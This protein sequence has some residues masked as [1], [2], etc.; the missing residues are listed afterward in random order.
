[1]EIRHSV[2]PLDCPDACAVLINVENGVGSRLRGDPQHPITQGF[3][4]A[5]VTKYLDRQYSSQR[6]LYPLKRV[7]AKGEGRFER[8]S[9]DEAL[10]TIATRLSSI[11]DEF[12]PEA[13]LPYSYAGTMGLLNGSGMDRRFFH[14]LGASRLDR[15]ICS[16]AG[17][18]GMTRAQGVRYSTE[19]EQF[20]ES[21]LILAWGANIHATNVHLW[22]F[23][24][25]ARRRG[26]KLYTIDPVLTRTG[27]LADKH[28]FINPGSDLAL[29]LGLMHVIIGERLYDADY[30]ANYTEGFDTLR[31]R[32]RKY[33]PEMVEAATGIAREDIV[34][35][36][37]EYA[38]TRPA[39]IR[40]NYGVQRSDRGASAIQAIATLPVLVGSWREVGGGIQLSTSQTF[41]LNRAGLEMPELQV[42]SRLGREARILNMST[43]GS[44]LL[45]VDNPPV[46]A[47]V[48]YNSNP[49][50]VA[51]DQSKVFRGMRREDLFTVVLEQMP[52]DTADFADVV[53]P[54]TTFLEHTDLYLAYGHLY[55][56][57]ARPALPPAGECK[58]NFEIFKLLAQRM[59][60][61]DACFRDSEDECIRT[62]LNSGHKFL[63]GI[64]L[65]R[66]EQ[67]RSVRLNVSAPGTP[68]LPF[69][70]GEF[71]TPSGKVDLGAENFEYT[72]PVES[73]FGD[74]EL[75]A[76]YPLEMVASKSH[77][78]MN[79]TFGFRSDTDAETAIVHLHS[80]DAAKRAIADGELVRVFNDRGSL[81]L[82]A[83][84]DGLV[85]E[86]VV[87]APSV[88]WPKNS[89]DRGNT[90]VLTSERLTD[91]GGG[92]TFF[93]CLVQVE[94]C[95]D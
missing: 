66:L 67:E 19:P 12:G 29:A 62:L 90:N 52:T 40:V 25:E 20:A 27:S 7:G 87:L 50:A 53:L 48:V 8:I 5:K 13:I 43:L 47:L 11:A 76:R 10:D 69:A 30:V 18:A 56:Q 2:C 38:T 88:R 14:R 72:P 32:V 24:V 83:K 64:T 65:E 95:G 16:S 6:L 33:T 84:V 28:F 77:N 91:F 9:W 36:A 45:E 17:M 23:I 79:S 75:Q 44:A 70:H 54:V 59:G 35:L 80:A 39:A 73:R 71:P 46:K 21:K 89:P 74:R 22:P 3:L 55:L 78:S 63:E 42:R 57:L 41:Q 94:K 61:D 92:P 58:S 93:S 31:E 4:C 85:K 86:G 82:K 34:H 60:F 26:A 81:R 37:R 15:T 49:A 1:M 68:W 51:P